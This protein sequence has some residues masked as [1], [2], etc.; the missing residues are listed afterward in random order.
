MN[1][2]RGFQRGW[3]LV[4]ITICVMYTASM[5]FIFINPQ[6]GSFLYMLCGEAVL[7][8]PLIVGIFMLFWENEP[9]GIVSG[10]GFRGFSVRLLPFVCLLPIAAQNFSVLLFFPL[11]AVLN[12]LFGLP[13][14]KDVLENGGLVGFLQN[15]IVL[16]VL[17]PVIEEA[18]CRGVLMRLFRRY[19]AVVMLVFSSLGFAL[20]HQSAQT[21]PAIFF[22]GMV[23]GMIRITTGSLFAAMAAHS[24]SN[25]YSL[26]LI[27][28][29]DIP[30]AAD[31]IISAAGMA[32]FPILLWYYMQRCDACTNWRG[33]LIKEHK[34]TGYS[35]G[36]VIVAV[37]F[38]LSNAAVLMQRIFDGAFFYETLY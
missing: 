5:P 36:L 17:A 37:L 20:L 7:A 4:L 12:L 23:L 30:V 8:I 38:A 27:T 25:L 10:M 19:G 11:Q 33:D 2:G 16:C 29:G 32:G 1:K 18:L 28:V 14:Y 15:F 21:L 13:D 3:W 6:E 22:L 24:A 35:V 34:P 26:I 31:Y 9:C